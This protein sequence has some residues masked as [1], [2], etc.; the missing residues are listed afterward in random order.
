MEII[1]QHRSRRIVAGIC[2]LLALATFVTSS[3]GC[4]AE[5]P[6]QPTMNCTAI[7]PEAWEAFIQEDDVEGIARQL[8]MD[9]EI[10][11]DGSFGEA[12]CD[13]GVNVKDVS[14]GIHVAVGGIGSHCLILSPIFEYEQEITERTQSVVVACPSNYI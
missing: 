13:R 3:S 12:H 1:K 11:R 2:G 8:R 9:E 5:G 4:S 14:R 7:M 10:V 6:K